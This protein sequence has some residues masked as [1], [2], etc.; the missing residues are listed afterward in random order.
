MRA[1][2]TPQPV[3]KVRD[4]VR[5]EVAMASLPS[6]IAFYPNGVTQFNPGQSAAAARGWHDLKNACCKYASTG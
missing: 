3:D 6:L 5:D 4:E 1:V 2:S